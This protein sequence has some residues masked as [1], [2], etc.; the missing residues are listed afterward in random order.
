MSDPTHPQYEG[1]KKGSKE[2]L[3]YVDD[4]YKKSYGNA[5]VTL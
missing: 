4:L 3:A 5:P 2:A 1:F